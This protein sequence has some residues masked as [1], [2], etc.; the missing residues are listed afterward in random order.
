MPIRL[1]LLAFLTLFHAFPQDP[2]SEISYGGSANDAIRAVTTDASGNIYVV[3]TTFSSDLPLLHPFQSVNSGTQVLSSTDAGV[4][5]TPRSNPVPSAT[6]LQP[7]TAA[8]DPTSAST[9]Y[10][11][12]GTTVCKSIDAGQHF[13]CVALPPALTI[14]TI[15]ALGIEPRRPTTLYAARTNTRGVLKSTDGGQTWMDASAGLPNLEFVY[16]VTVDPFHP[17]NVY[18]WT[19]SGGFVSRDGAGSWIPSGAPWPAA[20]FAGAF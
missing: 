2:L 18:V 1:T 5:W 14:G 7:L 9:L 16:S 13:H 4:S 15:T 17:G 12:S 6:P 11:G 3:G 19:D 10:V 8:V 20:N